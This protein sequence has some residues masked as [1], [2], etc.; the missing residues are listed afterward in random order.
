ME[1]DLRQILA[2]HG[3]LAVP[4][5]TLTETTNLFASGLDSLAI[6][7]VMLAIENTFD[8]EFPDEDLKRPTFA[9]LAAMKSAISRLQ[10]AA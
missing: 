10:S 7:N 6:V 8:I 2:K 9:S 4:V 1:Q 5:E 3:R